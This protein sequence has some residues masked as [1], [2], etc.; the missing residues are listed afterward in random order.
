MPMPRPSTFHEVV[1]EG[2]SYIQMGEELK[3]NP[4][5]GVFVKCWATTSLQVKVY[6]AL[7]EG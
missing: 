5:L 4:T 7:L 6:E 1:K 3:E 2:Y